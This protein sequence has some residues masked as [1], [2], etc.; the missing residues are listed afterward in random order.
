MNTISI[1]NTDKIVD[2][3]SELSNDFVFLIESYVIKDSLEISGKPIV[4]LV[5]I[6][7]I[8][9]V[10]MSYEAILNCHIFITKNVDFVKR[11]IKNKELYDNKLIGL[12]CNKY[13]KKYKTK[14]LC[15]YDEELSF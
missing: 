2:I 5:N 4:K 12:N 15:V 14:I 1:Y 9:K 10:I 11:L 7:E 6:N 13:K 3:L 8:E